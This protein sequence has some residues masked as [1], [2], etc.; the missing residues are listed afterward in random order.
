MPL[1]IIDQYGLPLACVAG[2]A[3][4]LWKILGFV[5]GQL[6]MQIQE[7]HEEEMEAIRQIEMEHQQFHQIIV[8]LI[9]NSKDNQMKL[10]EVS[11]KIDMLVKLINK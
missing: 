11:S 1:E 2:L 8:K 7:R 3:V 10:Q 4:A 5:Q 6:L 9:S